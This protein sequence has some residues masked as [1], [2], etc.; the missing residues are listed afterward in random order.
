MVFLAKSPLVSKYDLSSLQ[1]IWCGAAPLSKTIET[2]VK[3]RIGIRIVRQGYGMTEGTFAFCAQDDNNHTNGSVGILLKGIYARVIEVESGE[4]LGPRQKGELHFKGENI[5]KGYIGDK[6]ATNATIDADGWLHT[7][8]IGYY[9]ENG[10]WFVV[11]RI[12]ELIKYKGFQVPP[13]EIEALLL[14]HP[15]I[16]DV[17][18]VGLPNELTGESAFAF[19]VKQPG[20]KITEKEVIDFVAGE[21]LNS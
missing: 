18:V 21:K 19:V 10:E 17:G 11:D 7:G 16:K 4:C 3:N 6:H 2:E 15:K 12:K 14:T 5:M 20:M 9:D 1:V 13:A 8:D